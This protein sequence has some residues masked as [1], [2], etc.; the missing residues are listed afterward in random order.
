MDGFPDLYGVG[1]N[2]LQIHEGER[3]NS[4]SLVDRITPSPADMEGVQFL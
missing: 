3:K 4:K 2:S 1:K